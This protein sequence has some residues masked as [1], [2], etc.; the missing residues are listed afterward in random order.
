M[1]LYTNRLKPYVT[2]IAF[3]SMRLRKENMKISTIPSMDEL[4]F[5]SNIWLKCEFIVPRST[6]RY[7]SVSKTS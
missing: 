7:G 2:S 3:L 6:S 5:L 4:A 1:G